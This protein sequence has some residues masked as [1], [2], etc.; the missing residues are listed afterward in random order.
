MFA[1]QLNHVRVELRRDLTR[2]QSDDAAL[3]DRLI[4][5]ADRLNNSTISDADL[6]ALIKEVRDMGDQHQ[7]RQRQVQQYGTIYTHYSE[8]AGLLG[9]AST[10]QTTI[11]ELGEP[12]EELSRRLEGWSLNLRSQISSEKTGALTQVVTW[13]DRFSDIHREVEALRS[14]AIERFTTIQSRYR[15]LFTNELRMPQDQLFPLFIYNP[16]DPQGSYTALYTAVRDTFIRLGHGLTDRVDALQASIRQV[17]STNLERL[18]DTERTALLAQYSD[19]EQAVKAVHSQASPLLAVSLETVQ[20]YDPSGGIDGLTP[21]II[22]AKEGRTAWNNAQQTKLEL[23]RQLGQI[24]LK[25]DEAQLYAA[26]RQLVGAGDAEIDLAQ[27]LLSAPNRQEIWALLQVLYD[28]R[29][30]RI[31]IAAVSG[32]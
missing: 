3:R 21:L 19:L 9:Q 4:A 27:L 17:Q 24:A 13:R 23:D 22:T 16:L 7:Q 25:P 8:A 32:D 5:L 12:A 15:T 26:I 31:K 6:E 14:Q 20:Q 29:R 10:L 1:D 18:L 2:L 28:K 11:Y 30:L